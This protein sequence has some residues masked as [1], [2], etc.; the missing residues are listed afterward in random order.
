MRAVEDAAG[1][2]GAAVD[3]EHYPEVAVPFLVESAQGREER[4]DDIRVAVHRN[5]DGDHGPR[6]QLTARVSVH[7]RLRSLRRTESGVMVPI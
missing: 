7:R 1:V 2:V 3:H 6:K 5:D 4:R